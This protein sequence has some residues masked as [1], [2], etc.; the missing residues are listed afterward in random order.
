MRLRLAVK[1]GARMQGLLGA[2]PASDAR[3]EDVLLIAPCRRIHT[4][5]MRF[6]LD[7]AFL[8]ARGRVLRVVRGLAPGRLS[9][10]CPLAVA[11]LERRASDTPWVFAGQQIQLRGSWEQDERGRTLPILPDTPDAPGSDYKLSA[12]WTYQNN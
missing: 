4:F 12:C 10:A 2:T 3:E 8:D 11:V 6:A 9:R 7:V 1:T 5:G